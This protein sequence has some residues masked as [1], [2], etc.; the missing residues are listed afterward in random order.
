MVLTRATDNRLKAVLH[1]R[2]S[3][4][5]RRGVPGQG[6]PLARA[7]SDLRRGDPAARGARTATRRR[8][9][10]DVVAPMIRDL[11]VALAMRPT[12]GETV[13]MV[14]SAQMGK[15]GPP[16]NGK[17]CTSATSSGAS[18][19]RRAARDQ[20]ADDRRHGDGVRARRQKGASRCRSSAKAARRSASGTRRSTCAPRAAA[21]DLLRREQPDG[22]LDAGARAVGGARV[23][24]QGAGYGI[25]GITIDGT[26]PDAIAAA[27]TWAAE[28]ARAGAGAR[29]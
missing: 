21:G 20:R 27:F 8:W 17:D 16:M 14:L 6:L 25:P 10:G 3:A 9:R 4:L 18:C 24:R 29:R 7:G 22:A 23:R 11:G 13:R 2:R 15:A 19:R 5:R 26:D 28:R 12:T 1:R